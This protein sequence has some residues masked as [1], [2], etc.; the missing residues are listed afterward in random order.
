MASAKANDGAAAFHVHGQPCAWLLVVPLQGLLLKYGADPSTPRT[1]DDVPPL[2]VATT[3]GH[4][5]CLDALIRNGAQLDHGPVTALHMATRMGNLHAT[6]QLIKAGADVNAVS[7]DR[8]KTTPLILATNYILKRKARK[9]KGGK[10]KEDGAFAKRALGILI[11]AN[12]D[13][14]QVFGDEGDFPLLVAAELPGAAGVVTLLLQAG[15]NPNAAR[16]G[17]GAFP[18][19]QAAQDGYGEQVRA[20]LKASSKLVEVPPATPPLSFLGLA[21]HMRGF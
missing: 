8:Y 10:K 11:D 7:G 19:F 20:L 9:G 15:A 12:A 4:D 2:V 21:V 6:E 13:V 17:D 1:K 14:D 16:P 5:S 18:L 3:N